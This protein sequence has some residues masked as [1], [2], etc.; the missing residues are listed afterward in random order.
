MVALRWLTWVN[1]TPEKIEEL[2]E[3]DR[4]RQRCNR[5]IEQS[6]KYLEERRRAERDLFYQRMRYQNWIRTVLGDESLS[7]VERLARNLEEVTEGFQTAGGDREM[8][9]RLIDHVFD[10]KCGDLNEEIDQIALTCLGVINAAGV[11][12]FEAIDR[13]LCQV[14]TAD[15]EKVKASL[16]RKAAAGILTYELEEK[17]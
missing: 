1:M 9:H 17:A 12:L 13:A 11:N 2:N 15:P 5:A 4:L 7:L 10:R 3:I 8:A 16:R 6:N 14:E